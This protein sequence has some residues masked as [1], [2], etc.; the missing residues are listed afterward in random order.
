[1]KTSAITTTT[2]IVDRLNNNDD[3]TDTTSTNSKV[4][5]NTLLD[6]GAGDGGV[7]AKLAPLFDSVHVTEASSSMRWRLS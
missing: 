6:I 5:F 4:H 3:N 2:A 7:T 1:M